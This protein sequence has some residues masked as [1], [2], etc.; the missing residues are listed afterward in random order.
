ME[1]EPRG[2]LSYAA[3]F[4]KLKAR[5]AFSGNH[6]RVDAVKPLMQ[7]NMGALEYRA[8]ADGEFLSAFVT[9]EITFPFALPCGDFKRKKPQLSGFLY[10]VGWC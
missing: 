3:L 10:L 5:Y 6:K 4:G 1:H 7:R 9:P 8:C 2:F